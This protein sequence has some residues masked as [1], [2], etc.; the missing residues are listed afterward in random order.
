MTWLD[1]LIVGVAVWVVLALALALGF[2]RV[3]GALGE[4]RR[5]EPL[6]PSRAD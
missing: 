2:G 3:S 6:R 1:W 5:T 4:R